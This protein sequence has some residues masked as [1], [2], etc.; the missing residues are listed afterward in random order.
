MG[1]VQKEIASSV[2]L[3]DARGNVATPGYARLMLF[4]YDR[5]MVKAGPLALKEWDFYQIAAGD[6]VL[7]LTIGHV[8]YVAS[9]SATLF[10]IRTG[11]R[12]SFS[13]MKPLPLRSM[14]MPE[15]P[16]L[17]NVLETSGKDFSMRFETAADMHHL[18]LNGRDPALGEVW[19]DVTLKSDSQDEKMVIATPFAKPGQFYLNCKENYYTVS[20]GCRIGGLEVV[21]KPK[22]TALLDWGRGVWPFR[23][24]WFWGNGAVN[25]EGGRF[26]FNIG[27][28]F[29]D[30]R[31]ATENMFF[32]NGRAYK[33]GV[34]LVERDERDY[35]A[36]WRSRDEDGAFDFTMTP[37]YDNFT[38]T[39]LGLVHTQCHQVFG[40]YNGTAVLPDGAKIEIRDMLAFCEHAQNRW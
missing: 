11:E 23:H 36:P 16:E 7:Q 6:N 17:P 26:G 19:A 22:D 8:S 20:G 35:M 40:R 25:A 29:G 39:N 32:W 14:K 28:G 27:W 24:E 2:P 34:L 18:T 1:G 33:L 9:F 12:R 5:A 37:V 21:L 3:L 31:N 15:N 4:R 38:Q 10:S 30:T 13:R